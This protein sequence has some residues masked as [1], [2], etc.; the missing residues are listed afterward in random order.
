MC[1]TV[2]AAREDGFIIGADRRWNHQYTD[3]SIQHEDRGGKTRRLD[4]GGAVAASGDG[5]LIEH[6]LP[7]LADLEAP[8]LK[9]VRQTI[10]TCFRGLAPLIRAKLPGSE[11]ERTCFTIVLPEGGRWVS[12]QLLPTGEHAAPPDPDLLRVSF[13]PELAQNAVVSAFGSLSEAFGRHPFD[14]WERVTA[15]FV[16]GLAPMAPSMSPTSDIIHHHGAP[17]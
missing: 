4:G 9:S 7:A 8:T 12:Y 11:P 17:S 16:A 2:A 15:A 3:G 6:T 5:M 14:A 10:T 1:M 13:P